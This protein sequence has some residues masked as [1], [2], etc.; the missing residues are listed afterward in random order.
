LGVYGFIAYRDKKSPIV[1]IAFRKKK[2]T[3]WHASRL[4][5]WELTTE[6]QNIGG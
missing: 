3:S 2:Q 1:F 4:T 5:V 6:T